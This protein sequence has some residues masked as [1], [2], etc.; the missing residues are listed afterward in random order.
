MP[1]YDYYAPVAEMHEIKENRHD[2]KNAALKP[3]MKQY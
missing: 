3:N 2:L 1:V